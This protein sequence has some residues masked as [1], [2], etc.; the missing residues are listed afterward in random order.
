MGLEEIDP[1]DRDE[2]TSDTPGSSKQEIPTDERQL[3]LE[4]H[5][6][7]SALGR[8]SI[9]EKLR[10][11]EVEPAYHDDDSDEEDDRDFEPNIGWYSL[12]DSSEPTLTQNKPKLDNRFPPPPS[13][14]TDA[15]NRLWCRQI[16]QAR[17][18]G[19]KH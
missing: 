11:A 1:E 5:L 6:G 8:Q 10:L 17:R 12:Y 14:K 7:E 18:A 16:Q 4:M 13:T 15:F 3:A 9:H 2:E 19:R